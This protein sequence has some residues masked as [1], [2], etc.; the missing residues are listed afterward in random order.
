VHN[1]TLLDELLDLLIFTR[2]MQEIISDIFETQCKSARFHK[3]PLRKFA[4]QNN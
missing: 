3:Q 4:P 1:S 2:V